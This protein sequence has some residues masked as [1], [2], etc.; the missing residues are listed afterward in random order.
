[1]KALRRVGGYLTDI[2]TRILLLHIH[3]FQPPVIGVAEGGLEPGVPS[4]GGLV[5]RKQFWHTQTSWSCS[6]VPQ[7][8]DL[9]KSIKINIIIFFLNSSYRLLL[10]LEHLAVQ[11]NIVPVPQLQGCVVLPLKL[12]CKHSLLGLAQHRVQPGGW[13]VGGQKLDGWNYICIRKE[14]VT[15]MPAW[16][17]G[18]QGEASSKELKCS[19]ENYPANPLQ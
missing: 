3:H 17:R 4:V 11:H 9:Q 16:G 1:M 19:D 5:Y 18:G 15:D 13:S 12:S 6:R 2:K 7:P 8:C 10:L 14:G